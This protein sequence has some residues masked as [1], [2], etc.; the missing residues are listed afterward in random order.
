MTLG[1]ATSAVRKRA[2]WCPRPEPMLLKEGRSRDRDRDRGPAW[3]P[4]RETEGDPGSVRGGRP[5][6]QE[7]WL[8]FAPSEPLASP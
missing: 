2:G 5:G 6:R 1:S 4:G 7:A 3:S 8:A